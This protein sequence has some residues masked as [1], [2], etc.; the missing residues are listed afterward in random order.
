M[1]QDTLCFEMEEQQLFNLLFSESEPPF[2]VPFLG[3]QKVTILEPIDSPTSSP[4]QSPTSCMFDGSVN[5]VTNS[6]EHSSLDSHHISNLIQPDSAQRIHLGGDFQPYM[7][8]PLSSSPYPSPSQASL[9]PEM[10]S[11]NSDEDSCERKRKRPKRKKNQLQG[12]TAVSLDREQLL[13][14]TSQEL[15]DFAQT[16]SSSRKLNSEEQ[17]ELRIQRRLIKNR[18]YA[19]FSRKKKK[20]HNEELEWTLSKIT[21]E[22]EEL[23]RENDD[24]KRNLVQLKDYICSLN[25]SPSVMDYVRNFFTINPSA[26]QVQAT[27]ACLL[28]LVVSFGVFF[29][30]MNVNTEESLAPSTGRLLLGNE[31]ESYWSFFLSVL[32]SPW[33]VDGVDRSEEQHLIKNTTFS[34]N[35]EETPPVETESFATGEKLRLE[36]ECQV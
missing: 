12:N 7:S 28:V 29:N 15:E 35:T 19:Q 30:L 11:E 17:K 27:T 6:P 36:V 13:T 18:E 24:L 33:R 9:V 23:R 22:N 32:E 1:Q 21:K 20:S 2:S 34:N 5:F 4:S 14:I 8:P 16:V 25:P 3:E 26:N 31:D 10:K